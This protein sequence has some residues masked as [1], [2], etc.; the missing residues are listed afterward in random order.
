MQAR[1]IQTWRCQY[2]DLRTDSPGTPSIS[3]TYREDIPRRS[4][5]SA[6]ITPLTGGVKEAL[7]PVSLFQQWLTLRAGYVIPRIET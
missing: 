2:S 5:H 4:V 7:P 3:T 6:T 1:L